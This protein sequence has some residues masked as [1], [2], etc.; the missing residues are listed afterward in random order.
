MTMD[1]T[2]APSGLS[3]A[4][5]TELRTRYGENTLPTQHSTSLIGKLLSQF[6]NPLIYIL[7]FALL[8]DAGIW[9]YEGADTFPL[10]SLAILIIL[11]V[12]AC[13]GFWQNLKSEKALSNLERLTEPQCWVMRDNKI[14]RIE[15]R[16]LVP[17]DIVRIEAGER[18]PA[19]GTILQHSGFIVDESIV[20][21][22]SEAVTKTTRDE[23]LSG[24]VAARGT[25][26]VEVTATG[27]NS[28]MGKMA[29]LLAGVERDKT[30]LE[31]RLQVIGRR[32]AMV[33]GL[34]AA[35]LWFAG[36]Y[37]TGISH[38]GELFI[39]VVALAVAAVPESLPAVITFTL[40]LGVERMAK[41]KAVVRKLS[42]VEALGS[43]TTIATDK[44]GTL[45]EN[46]MTVQ[47]IDVLDLEESYRAMVLVSDA[48]LESGLGDPMELGI[49]AYV[50]AQDSSL[51]ATIRRDFPVVSSRPF[52][53]QWKYMRITTRSETGA[54]ISYLK[55]APEILLQRSTLG[56]QEQE[57]WQRRIDEF[58][59]KGYRALALARSEGEAEEELTWLGLIFLL[60][61]P[62]P[63]V[64][65]SISQALVAGIRVLMITGDHPA[66]AAEIARQ[67]GISGEQCATGVQLEQ[68]T[69]EEFEKTIAST[70]V[71]ARVSPEMKFR[72]VET[73]QAQGQVVAVTGD[74]VNDA[75]ALKAADVGVAM[76]QRGSDV[77]REVADLVLLDDNFVSIVAAIEEGRN[78]F[79][80]IQ[81]IIRFL[82]A[83]NL[84]E[85]SLIVI[86]S[87]LAFTT[88]GTEAS[89][90]LPLTA[91][92]ILWINMLTDSIPALAIT[93]D[94]SSGL[95]QERPHS[96]S[97]QLLDRNSLLFIL[98]IG[99]LGSS[100]ALSALISLPLLGFDHGATQTLVFAYLMIVQLAVVNPARQSNVLTEP[101]RLVGWALGSSLL[102]QLLVMSVPT[103]RS[104]LGLS[105]LPWELAVLL[106]VMLSV[107][108]FLAR[109][110]SARLRSL[111]PAQDRDNLGSE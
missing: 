9:L 7:L 93:L 25:A 68:M 101:N 95:L 62:R 6:R 23:V 75:P 31:K 89:I 27:L 1:L 83:A 58:A 106:L 77:S 107:S 108:W 3:A 47:D 72:I 96:I 98:A 45:T 86:G 43:V 12:N 30:P 100:F 65:D 94:R 64:P 2:Q 79:E 70:N 14:Q 41:R 20:T 69:P 97:A 19:D 59:G 33:I 53:A 32:L 16:L 56:K 22:E 11:L 13:L 63:E 50:N 39:F 81:K 109:A 90:I 38:L 110:C 17:G 105:I 48:D 84:A 15:S 18:L 73:L 21:G 103:L 66:T 82:F 76:G 5:V 61:P 28:N 10:E 8:V 67:I 57:D 24:T 49:L 104:L 46:R 88:V 91:A 87:L 85:V 92:Q 34:T 29:S 36:L 80:N 42:A 52:D 51:I 44:T 74:G 26:F 35:L 111:R 4:Q 40:A 99:I 37:L 55:G 78:I 60:D 102:L 71:F 54:A